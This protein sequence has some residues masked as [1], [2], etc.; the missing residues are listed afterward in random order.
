MEV[1]VILCIIVVC[2]FIGRAFE[3]IKQSGRLS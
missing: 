3:A 1:F 2:F